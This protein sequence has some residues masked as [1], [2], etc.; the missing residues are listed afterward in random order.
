T[1][2][3]GTEVVTMIPDEKS[4]VS[5]DKT[6]IK[7]TRRELLTKIG[8]GVGA[9][10]WP[11]I[12]KL[13]FANQLSKP[14]EIGMVT[15]VHYSSQEQGLEVDTKGAKERLE[16]F[17][18]KMNKWKPDF[19]V[20]LGDYINARMIDLSEKG[21]KEDLTAIESVYKSF[22]GSRHYVFGNHDL[23]C[24]SRS[25]FRSLTGM[26]HYYKSFDVSGYHFLILNV[27]YDPSS[28][29][30]KD[31]DFGYTAGY[32]PHK[33]QDWLKKDLNSTEKPTIVLVHQRLD[34][35]NN[36]NVKNAP[37]VRRIFGQSEQVIGVFQ[38]HVHK[39][40]RKKLNG[41]HYITLEALADASNESAWA[42][43]KLDPKGC[44]IIVDGR[45]NQESYELKY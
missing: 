21:T 5:E 39:N 15:D 33:E 38:G 2:T 7:L 11:G 32:L 18:V 20:E 19:I 26:E 23:Y 22:A 4:N 13:S 35:Q 6:N 12:N 29:E 44:R 40:T 8:C 41:T 25:Q 37:E 14:V 34:V 9:G 3:P 27:Q 45:Y 16:D 1:L 10:L 31:Q 43:V 17:I 36:K 24:L 30:N 42:K 28:G